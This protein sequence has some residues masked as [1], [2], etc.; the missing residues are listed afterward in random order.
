MI[1]REQEN[2]SF[3]F[4]IGLIKLA[5]LNHVYFDII[6]ADIVYPPGKSIKTLIYSFLLQ[7]KMYVLM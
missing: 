2:D 7:S 6:C 1:H 4:E 5:V 3:L